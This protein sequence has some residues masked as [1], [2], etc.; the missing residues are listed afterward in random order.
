MVFVVTDKT[1]IAMHKQICKQ[2][3]EIRQILII[4]FYTI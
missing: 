4:M 2:K 3:E 1:A